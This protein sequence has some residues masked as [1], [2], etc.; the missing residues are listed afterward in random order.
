MKIIFYGTRGQE[1]KEYAARLRLSE[2]R[3]KVVQADA[4]KE[5]E[6][7]DDL[8]FL[9]VSESEKN[10][11]LRLFGFSNP[12]E[13]VQQSESV[14]SI[15]DDWQAMSWQQLR[16]LAGKLTDKAIIN[17]REASEVIEAE[18]KRRAA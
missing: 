10:R 17:K 5:Q 6:P 18:L 9:D 2:V 8:E 4:C 3:C 14:V 11:L 15:P 7:C 1:A 12:A 16:R 13:I